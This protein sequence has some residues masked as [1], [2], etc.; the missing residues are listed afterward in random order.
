VH[1]A[2]DEHGEP[3][4][5]LSSL[6]GTL[7][8]RAAGGISVGQIVEHFGR[9]AFG[10]V[11][12]VFALLNL[13]P[14]PP[15]TSTLLGAPILLLAPQL[16]FGARTPWLPAAIAR[17][18]LG[19]ALIA[20]F[21]RRTSAELRRAER[22]TGP[23]LGMMFGRTGELL[24]GATCTLLAVILVLPIPLGNMLPAAAIAVLALALV[25]R[26][27][28]LA[29][30]GYLMAAASLL[31]LWLTGHAIWYAVERLFALLV[32]HLPDLSP[33]PVT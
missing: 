15:G 32:M 27:G 22:V 26:D 10:A 18:N 9:R 4:I 16:A 25:Q 19:G 24:L 23:R 13:I 30:V 6:M 20:R 1:E 33:L 11:L 3:A 8:D 5:P 12:F 7:A 14:C 28:V 17:G 2:A 29:L 21:C 31:V